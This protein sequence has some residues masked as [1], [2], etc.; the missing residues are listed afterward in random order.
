V[1]IHLKERRLETAEVISFV[2][3]LKGEPFEYQPGQY[4]FYELDA[5]NFPD[6]RGNRRHFTISSSPTEKG[7]VMLTTRMRG[8]GFKETLRHAPLGYGLS[9]G[10]PLGSF[11]MP[12]DQTRHHVFVAGG[13]GVTPFRSIL[14]YAVD[15]KKPI[16]AVMLYFNHSS[17]DIV[18]QQELE[19]ISK[20]MPTFS[21]VNVLSAPEPSWKGE[22]ERLSEY[23]LRRWVPDLDRRLFWISG[24]PPMV[25][26]YKTSI[27]QTGVSDE[28]IR[29]DNFTGY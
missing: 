14:R 21:I 1:R 19:E 9:I 8:S 5:L 16:D 28:S 22:K 10:T 25:M 24:P 13:I 4:V 20:L 2:F 7:I 17:S 29:T 15:A 27:K 11:V 26:A 12:K 6:E 23:L 18:F 3:D